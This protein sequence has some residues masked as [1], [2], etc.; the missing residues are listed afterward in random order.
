MSYV[1]DELNRKEV[2]R[3]DERGRCLVTT[4]SSTYIWHHAPAVC[5]LEEKAVYSSLLIEELLFFMAAT[6][7]QN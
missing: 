6:I 4:Q 7:G 3:R 2:A 5:Y 1:R